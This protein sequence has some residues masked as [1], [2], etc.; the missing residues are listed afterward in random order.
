MFY[1]G[2]ENGPVFPSKDMLDAAAR[3]ESCAYGG[4]REKQR[5][6]DACYQ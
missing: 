2:N 6:D 4:P 1:P 5:Y 3:V